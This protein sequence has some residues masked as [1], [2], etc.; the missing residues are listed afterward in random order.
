MPA[1]IKRLTLAL[2]AT[3]AAGAAD[4]TILYSFDDQDRLY[5][6]DSSN[7]GTFLSTVQVTGLQGG[8]EAID[9]RP[10]NGELFGYT[11]ANRLFR[12]DI[13]TGLATGIGGANPVNGELF[14][15]DF[16][17]TI[18][19]IR[20]VSAADTNSVLNPNDGSFTAATPVF[21]AAGDVNA[22]TNPNITGN[23]Y[24]PSTFGAPGTTTQL[25]AIDSRNDVLARQ[26]NSAGTL[27]TVGGLGFDVS[28]DIGFDI[29]VDGMGFVL[30]G[31]DLYSIDLATGRLSS[32]GQ[33]ASPLYG[34][35]AGP[36][37]VPAPP[38]LAL[39]ALALGAVGY[40]RRRRPAP[41][42]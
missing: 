6:F 38:A 27:N 19:R 7:P 41:H 32:L 14:G 17:P 31:R 15:F 39:L 30:D 5:S 8:L 21:Y 1:M 23:A 35:T 22:G 16:N 40:S 36:V 13:G 9:F 24:T 2:A 28:G 34:V 4:A 26:A 42:A 3:L 10:L 20:L 11:D 18:D 37:P 12:I 29:A 33:T 25:Y